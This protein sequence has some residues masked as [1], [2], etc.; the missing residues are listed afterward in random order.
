M[1]ETS[2]EAVAVIQAGG[3]GGSDQEGGGGGGTSSLTP[4]S[5]LEGGCD[6]VRPKL[7]QL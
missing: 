7:S 1:R 6:I 3:D 5:F 2:E 4:N